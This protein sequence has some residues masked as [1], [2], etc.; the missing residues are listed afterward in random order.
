MLPSEPGLSL[1]P[2]DFDP[3]ASFHSDNKNAASRVR[4][5]ARWMGSAGLAWYE[6]D[7]EGYR[8]SLL[9]AGRL[10]TSVAAHLSTVR[11]MYRRL[12]RSNALRDLLYSMT[13]ADSPPERRKA[14]V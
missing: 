4:L 13:P 9:A 11:G 8:D 1:P 14:F 5:F 2:T 12:L 10:P 6:P 7:L 3:L